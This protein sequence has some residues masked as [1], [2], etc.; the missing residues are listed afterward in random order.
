MKKNWNTP[1]LTT[2]GNVEELTLGRR[3]KTVGKDDGTDLVV[4]GLAPTAGTPIGS[5]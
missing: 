4:P 3:T 5:I 1:K 2:Y